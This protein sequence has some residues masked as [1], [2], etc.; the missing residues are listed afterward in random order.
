MSK[1][2]VWP[3]LNYE[4]VFH[5]GTMNADQKGVRGPSYEGSGLSVSVHPEEWEEIAELGGL[6]WWK[7]ARKD[8]RFLDFHALSSAQRDEIVAWGKVYDLVEA[9][10]VWVVE[11]E[12]DEMETTMVRE[13]DTEEEAREEAE[14]LDAEAPTP[15]LGLKCTR[16]LLARMGWTHACADALDGV[17]MAYAEDVLDIDGVWWNDDLAPELLSA[18][19]GVIFRE[20]LDSWNRIELATSSLEIGDY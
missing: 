18:P 14:Y 17:A 15:K 4:C 7:L 9:A 12:D 3:I 10:V 8:A 13:F 19:R 2:K 1:T 11:Y 6:P 5:I 16:G 20:R